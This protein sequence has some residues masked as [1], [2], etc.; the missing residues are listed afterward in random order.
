MALSRD[1]YRALEDV[2]GSENISEEPATLDAYAYQFGAELIVRSNF[3]T[4]PE[5]VIMP[6]STEEVQAIV[7]TCNRFKVK[8]KA[9]STGWFFKAAPYVP[10]VVQL[11]MRRMN[12]ILDIDEKNMFAI[13]EPYV[14]AGQLQAEA[15][16][17]GLNCNMIGAGASCSP[18]AQSCLG[19][20]GHGPPSIYMGHA[21]EVLLG[22]E[23][24][25]PTGDILRTGTLGSGMGWF[26]GEGPG[27][28]LR[29]IAR[30]RL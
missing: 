29:A 10:G 17:V 22:M 19:F 11:D 14:I 18:L 8:Y 27:P 21:S 9:L 16:K 13:I 5:A 1:S 26:C 20:P 24:V 3:M 23:W 25:M 15:M 7:K 6:G 2:V 28:S 4:R 12:R 30:G